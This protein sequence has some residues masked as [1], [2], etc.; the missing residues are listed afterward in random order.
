MKYYKEKIYLKDI[1]DA[2]F[3][4]Q[5]S[6]FIVEIDNKGNLIMICTTKGNQSTTQ[7]EYIKYF[8]LISTDPE[9]W[10]LASD[11]KG[12]DLMPISK[13]TKDYLLK[14][15]TCNIRDRAL[16]DLLE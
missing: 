16:D 1:V 14:L 15:R 7:Y 4:L 3:P 13:L 8:Y 5:H 11:D 9:Y 6:D 2:F 12:H 10:Y